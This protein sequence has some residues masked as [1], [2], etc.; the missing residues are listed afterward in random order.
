MKRTLHI[1]TKIWLSISILLAGYLVLV[2]MDFNL[3]MQMKSRLKTVSKSLIPAARQSEIGVSAFAE[4]LKAHEEM[5]STG[6][7]EAIH[8]SEERAIHVQ[9]A[10]DLIV[11]ME[12]VTAEQKR[13]I[14]D[15]L[16]AHQRFSDQAKQTYP[17]LYLNM[18]FDQEWTP[19]KEDEQETLRKQAQYLDTQAKML[20]TEFQNIATYFNEDLEHELSVIQKST[21][22]QAK[23]NM[24]VFGFVAVCSL[25]LIAL[26]VNR[27]ITTPLLRI[28]EIAKNITAGGKEIEWLT[29]RNDE[30][31]ILNSSLRVMT[32]NL[33]DEIQERKRAEESVREAEKKYR[34][35]FENSFDGIFQA[36]MQGHLLDANP[37]LA[38]ILG[39]VSPQELLAKMTNITDRLECSDAERAR[40]EDEMEREGKI[41][42]F[43]SRLRQKSGA[44]I[45][46]SMSARRIFDTHGQLL[47]Y[48]GS[49]RD[50]TQRKE[51]EA[52][53]LAY[54]AEIE[55]QVEQRT[56]ELSNALD[57][58]KATQQELIHSEKMA[59]LGHLVAGVAHEIN[60][61]LGAIRA[62]ISN[63]SNALAET[64]QALPHLFQK[65]TEEQQTLFFHLLHRALSEKKPH[66]TSREERAIKRKLREQLDEQQAVDAETL[67]D[68]LVD[69][70]IYDDITGFMTLF[71]ASNEA[72]T[73]IIQTAYNLSIQQHHSDNI[74]TAVER[75]SKVVFALKS[76]AHYDHSGEMSASSIT[77]GIDVVL[78]LYHNKL[79]HGVDVI[80]HYEPVPP[81]KC[82]FD[83]L[84]QVWTN[85]I[86][87]GI[88]AMDGHGTLEIS[89]SP[90]ACPSQEGAESGACVVVRITDSGCGIP[91]EIQGRIFEPFFTTKPA[92]EGSG[93]GLDIC[94]KIVDKHH[95]RIEVESQPGKTT[96]SVFLPLT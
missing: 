83:E 89:V 5:A 95:G 6:E 8:T 87:N 93:L 36:D 26:I 79:K 28:V 51:A 85:L 74:I 16:D 81:V 14:R 10:F 59:A 63:I 17:K 57:H 66:L 31:G 61:P 20:V 96:F 86:H 53:Q 54:Q 40:F 13:R 68:T 9:N 71:A 88:Q 42:Q 4:Q 22:I 50:I 7:T 46:I 90:I 80:K 34:G 11:R 29:E 45:W 75:A 76:Y 67:A 82:Y 60:T 56:L 77:D 43:E 1:S 32:E 18:S 41:L 35:I 33:Q 3:G 38:Q 23:R 55:K 27:S 15:A 84:N 44:I 47:Y 73:S 78:T 94:R 48:E 37:A 91:P 64:I 25:S 62:S 24:V 70:G 72:S 52:L 49:F 2:M 58:L 92:G 19:I 65:L 30:I 21:Y 12:D 39:Y 69:M